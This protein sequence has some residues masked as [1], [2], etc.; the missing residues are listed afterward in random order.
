MV[1]GG[2]GA[3]YDVEI[4]DLNEQKNVTLKKPADLPH[5]LYGM[6][7]GV[8]GGQ[9]MVCTGYDVSDC[10][11]YDFALN[12]W[13]ETVSLYA[14]RYGGMGFV[15]SEDRWHILGGEDLNP[16]AHYLDT[17]VFYT[18]GASAFETGGKLPYQGA[19]GCVAT[20]NETHV[21]FAG[22]WDGY[23]YRKDAHLLEVA[24]WRWTRLPDMSVERADQSCGRV[25]KNNILV[26]GGTPEGARETSE[27]FNLLT[28]ERYEGPALPTETGALYGV[29]QVYQVDETFFVIGGKAGTDDLLDS[30]YEVDAESFA[31]RLRDERLVTAREAHAVVPIPKE[32]LREM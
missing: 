12:Q 10:Y 21:F 19:F 24:E 26:I 27:V 30:V 14:E 5:S 18:Q 9:I 6:V 22:G 4:L 15:S 28:G 20:V 7:A 1:I 13:N 16:L 17:S 31:L 11:V 2:I 23:K 32:M 3:V 29:S 8:V 25:G